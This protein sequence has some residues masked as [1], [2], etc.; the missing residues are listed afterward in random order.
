MSL[1]LAGLLSV[2][3]QTSAN[4]TPTPLKS[5]YA[6]LVIKEALVWI[7]RYLGDLGTMELRSITDRIGYRGATSFQ[8]PFLFPGSTPHFKPTAEQLKIPD[9]E[10]KRLRL[11]HELRLAALEVQKRALDVVRSQRSGP[12]HHRANVNWRSDGV[13]K[14]ADG[15]TQIFKLPSQS[16]IRDAV[17]GDEI[18]SPI[19][20]NL[21]RLS[22]A[23]N[24]TYAD[25]LSLWVHELGHKVRAQNPDFTLSEIDDLAIQIKF[26]FGKQHRWSEPNE[27]GLQFLTI[28]GPSRYRRQEEGYPPYPIFPGQM[29]SALFIKQGDS[30]FDLGDSIDFQLDMR[31]S[32]HQN[33]YEQVRVFKNFSWISKSEFILDIDTYVMPGDYNKPQFQT[34]IG[35]PY[36]KRVVGT[37]DPTTFQIHVH[38]YQTVDPL[39]ERAWD[40]AVEFEHIKWEK[41]GNFII[42]AKIHTRTERFFFAPT[43]PDDHNLKLLLQSGAQTQ[44]VPVY[45]KAIPLHADGWGDMPE[46]AYKKE[47][48]L[49]IELKGN[50]TDLNMKS[51]IV[52]GVIARFLKLGINYPETW[53]ESMKLVIAQKPLAF[54]TP[55][56][57]SLL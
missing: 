33:H 54:T 47:R 50:F 7:P 31:V 15:N 22:N 46:D 53:D 2:N 25:A 27:D 38:E 37:I 34:D 12:H 24:F 41:N 8:P 44:R 4:E 20:F 10:L 39:P 11:I 5:G 56:E 29:P 21:T 43:Y 30:Y 17:T 1:I 36:P 23:H 13:V 6:H 40:A 26:Y 52:T 55:C 18:E 51:P 35:G 19:I 49:Q 45:M 48:S 32:K 42:L 9:P 28:D 3:A 16:E 14:F 57:S